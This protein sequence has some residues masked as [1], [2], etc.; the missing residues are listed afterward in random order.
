MTENA[1]EVKVYDS[2]VTMLAELG[3]WLEE[4]AAQN[5][6]LLGL[7]YRLARRAQAGGE[8][9]AFLAGVFA[10]GKPK[11][12]FLHVQPRWEVV[13]VSEADGWEELM[14]AA[15]LQFKELGHQF[16]GSVGPEPM[17]TAF[18]QGMGANY[19]IVFRQFVWRL[20][21]LVWPRPAA[22]EMRL[23]APKDAAILTRWMRAFFKEALS[24]ELSLEDA[25]EA[26]HSKLLER[27][28]YVWDHEGVQ[29]MAGVERPTEQGITVVLVYTPSAARGHGYASNL[30]AH[31]T[32]L[33]L[34]NGRKF[35]CLHTDADFPTSNKIYAAL[36]YYEV[37]QGSILRFE[38]PEQVVS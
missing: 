16:A 7:L 11:L 5:N 33:Q 26:I 21:R 9:E 30:V 22:G 32:D 10:N 35:L 1:I 18:A 15:I 8:V 38:L 20:D 19:H 4:R 36:G 25:K 31:M 23:A 34:R 28:L 12:A 27:K 37:G 17:N 13:I 24:K 2:P 14:A 3:A 29:S 6:L